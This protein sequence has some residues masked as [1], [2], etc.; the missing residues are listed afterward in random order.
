M[1]TDWL[2]PATHGKLAPKFPMSGFVDL[3]AHHLHGL[4]DGATSLDMALQSIAAVASLGFSE[5]FATPHQRAGMFLPPW[6]DVERAWA[7]LGPRVAEKHPGVTLRLGAENFWDEVLHDRLVNGTLPR[8]GDTAAF[9]FEINPRLW[10]PGMERILFE[11][12]LAGRLPAMA[13]PERYVAVQESL[14]KAEV[15]GRSAALVIDL[16]A[17]EG[18]HGRTEMK[19]SRRLLEEGLAHAAATDIHRPEDQRAIAAGMAWIRKRFGE[20][21]LAQLLD[22]GPRRILAGEL[23]EPFS[24]RR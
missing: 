4:D 12:R 22:D 17:L 10:P 19:T 20:G 8:Y 6:P 18:A 11:Q 2:A 24:P 1:Q 3:H 13:H 9:L 14:E 21:A 23:P 5:L 7:E 15:V 16:G